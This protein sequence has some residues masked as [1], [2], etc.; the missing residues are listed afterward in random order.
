MIF[1][2]LCMNPFERHEDHDT[3]K[4]LR[5]IRGEIASLQQSVDDGLSLLN[6]K[7]DQ[8]IMQQGTGGS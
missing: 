7:I 8:V 5:E 4:I 3:H 6:D 2:V 1:Y